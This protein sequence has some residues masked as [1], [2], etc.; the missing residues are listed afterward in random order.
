MIETERG[1]V[2]VEEINFD[3]KVKSYDF[4]RDGGAVFDYYDVMSIMRPVI[5][6]KWAHV[7]TSLGHELKCTEDHPLFTLSRGSNELPINECEVGTKIWVVQGD[8]M[9][10]DTI[11]SIEYFEE[12]VLVYNFE[13]RDV[14]SYLS[15]GIL[16]H[17]K[18][19]D[20]GGGGR[21]PRETITYSDRDIGTETKVE[22]GTQTGTS[23]GSGIDTG[24]NSY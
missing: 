11:Q 15:N 7:I 8:E 19:V 16:S 14:H 22:D 23:P 18:S 20:S 24:G 3:D 17:N 12:D 2:P 1:T 9:I 5:K 21:A 6:S 4:D 13:V 10:R